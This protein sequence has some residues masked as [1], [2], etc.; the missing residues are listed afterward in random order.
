MY[1]YIE[2]LLHNG[3]KEYDFLRNI[4]G[5]SEAWKKWLVERQIWVALDKSKRETEI[6]ELYGSSENAMIE[7]LRWY[8]P[9]LTLFGADMN[10]DQ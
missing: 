6:N 4:I 3:W 9:L 2:N 7:M 1:L 5:S 8:F 10:M